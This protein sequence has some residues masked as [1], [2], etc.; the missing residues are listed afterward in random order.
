LDS[1]KAYDREVGVSCFHES[2]FTVA[3]V[4]MKARTK[5]DTPYKSQACRKCW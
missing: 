1:L 5:G 2:G 4:L 3:A